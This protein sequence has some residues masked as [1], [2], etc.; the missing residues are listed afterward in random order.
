VRFTTGRAT[1]DFVR[2]K[3]CNI[4]VVFRSICFVRVLIIL[5]DLG[6]RISA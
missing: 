2:E 4:W 3:G 5:I 6:V 1:A